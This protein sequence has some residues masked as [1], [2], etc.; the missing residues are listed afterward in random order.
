MSERSPLVIRLLKGFGMFWWDFLVGDTP[1]LFAA[2][3]VIIGAVALS[4]I[5]LQENALA[6]ALLPLLAVVAGD[7]CRKRRRE[8][9]GDG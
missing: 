1:E 3:I 9:D 8:G 5:V 2:A 7:F 4:R 6:V